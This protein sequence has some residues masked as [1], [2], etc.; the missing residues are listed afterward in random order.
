MKFILKKL[1]K[2][3]VLMCERMSVTKLTFVTF[4]RLGYGRIVTRLHHCADIQTMS[5]ILEPKGDESKLF[6]HN[7]WKQHILK[8][9]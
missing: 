3:H 6:C 9:L 7:T 4:G 5:K 8:E 2:C 1:E